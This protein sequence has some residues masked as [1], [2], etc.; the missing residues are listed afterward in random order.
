[1]NVKIRSLDYQSWRQF[2]SEFIFD[3]FGDET[4]RSDQY[5]FRGQREHQW[6]LESSF[7]RWFRTTFGEAN[8]DRIDTAK[9]LLG[10][11]TAEATRHGHINSSMSET[12]IVALAQHHGLPTRL[13]DWSASPYVAAFFAVNE[14]V[15]SGNTDGHAAIWALDLRE[16]VWDDERGVS[17]VNASAANV[18]R[19][20]SQGGH[21]TLNRTPF[22]T[23]EEYVAKSPGTNAALVKA[24]VPIVEARA[25]LADLDA[26]GINHA[27]AYPEITGCVLAAQARVLLTL[28]S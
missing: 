18:A 27:A 2:K 19:L 13:L 17:I 21:F 12:D 6:T 8:G 26:M 10:M 16:R 22:P 23:L 9:R 20:R 28:R 24:S 3:L 25:A 15:A 5:L 1:V 7:D 11:F 4:F 14:A